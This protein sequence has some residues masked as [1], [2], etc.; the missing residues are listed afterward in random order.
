VTKVQDFDFDIDYVKGKKNIVADA[1]SR[2][3]TT[4]SL[5]E[6]SEDWKPHLLV[7]YSKN[8]FAFEVLD[9]QV[10]D[11]RYKV[12]DDVIFY[13][14]KVYLVLG[15]EFKNKI[16]A[17]IHDSPL[18]GH[19]GFFKAYMQIIERFSWKGLM[20][21]VMRYIGEFVTCQQNMSEHTLPTGLHQSLPILEQKW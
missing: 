4:C 17:T 2:R 18:V 6:V 11:D 5:M 7:E 10:Q 20:K 3:P 16:L 12:V 19:H 15:S 13:K 9:G 14:D 1:L 8:K 21:D